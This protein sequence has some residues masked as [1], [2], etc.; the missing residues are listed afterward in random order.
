MEETKKGEIIIYRAPE[1]PEVT[2]Q[3]EG[4]TAWLTLN[5]MAELFG[6]DKSVISRHL[7]NVFKSA[8]LSENSVVAKYATTASDGKTYQVEYYNL[9][10][11]ISVGYRINSKRG[12]QFRVW[13]TQQLRNY[14]LKGYVINERRLLENQTAKLRE[15]ETAHKLIQQALESKRSEG[16]EREL[17][18]IISDYANAWFV[19]MKYDEQKLK[20]EN[21]SSGLG[22][23]LNYDE[24]VKAIIRFRKRL[25]EQKQ[26]T[27]IFGVEVSHK[28]ASIIG[29]IDQTFGGNPLYKSIEESSRTPFVFCD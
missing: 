11:I 23:A 18:K 6:R 2:V 12:T 14:I 29:N 13:A 8:E 24:V 1:G 9:D 5:Q 16:Y 15:L 4:E 10:A 21:V 7:S 22:K 20:I 25:R 3:F 26:A 19:L 17:L 28:L 27:D